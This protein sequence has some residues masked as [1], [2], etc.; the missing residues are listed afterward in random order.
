MLKEKCFLGADVINRDSVHKY[1][2]W[3]RDVRKQT[4]HDAGNTPVQNKILRLKFEDFFL[5]YNRT[6]ENIKF[7]LDIDFYHKDKGSKFNPE[8]VSDHIGIWKNI[9]DQGAMLQIEKE[10]GEYCYTN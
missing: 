8:S 10:L 1:I 5:H 4:E 2:K 7:F 3:H 6:I 9:S